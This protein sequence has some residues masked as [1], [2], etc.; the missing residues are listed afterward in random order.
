MR[1]RRF[2]K[3]GKVISKRTWIFFVAPRFIVGVLSP[4]EIEPEATTSK[5][6]PRWVTYSSVLQHFQRIN[7]QCSFS[8]Y[9]NAKLRLALRSFSRPTLRPITM[10]WRFWA[11]A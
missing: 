1:K 8:S 9:K 5:E 7:E 3:N 6:D 2:L 11:V 10:M 4:I